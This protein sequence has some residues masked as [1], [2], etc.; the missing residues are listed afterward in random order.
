MGKSSLSLALDK[1]SLLP[2]SLN[3][4]NEECFIML[5]KS[6]SLMHSLC[7]KTFFFFFCCSH[8]SSHNCFSSTTD[9][10]VF[11]PCTQKA[12]HKNYGREVEKNVPLEELLCVYFQFHSKVS[13][14]ADVVKSTQL[15]WK[16]T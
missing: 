2:R 1:H 16:E 12:L 4:D 11:F 3:N 9:A 13:K 10:H 6:L 7:A 14:I 8:R 5:R 15:Y